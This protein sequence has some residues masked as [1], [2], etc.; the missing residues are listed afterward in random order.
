[1]TKLSDKQASNKKKKTGAKR[2]GGGSGG[3]LNPL[4]LPAHAPIHMH[5]KAYTVCPKKNY[6]RTFRI[7]NFKSLKWIKVRFSVMEM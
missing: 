1:M 3:C 4:S 6:N 5:E 2:G 7:N